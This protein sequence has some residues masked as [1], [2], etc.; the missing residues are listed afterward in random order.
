MPPLDL[1]MT[2]MHSSRMQ[3]PSRGGGVCLG[4]LPR[5]CLPRERDVCP[6]GVCLGEC[7][8][9]CLPQGVSTR[10]VRM[11]IICLEDL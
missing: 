2:R 6:G 10:G 5:G 7:A 4:C 3:W 11:L 9:G 8:R 1:P